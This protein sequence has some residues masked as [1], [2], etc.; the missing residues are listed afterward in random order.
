MQ[1]NDISSIE[2]ITWNHVIINI[3]K[4][5]LK[6]SDCVLIICISEKHLM[7][8]NGKIFGDVRGVMVIVV[9]I[10]HGYTSSNRWRVWLHFI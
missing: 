5:Y 7:L 9:E 1:A 2:I 10:T 3:R 6:S 4:E 8:Y